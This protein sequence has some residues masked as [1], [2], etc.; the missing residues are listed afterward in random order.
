MFLTVS[1]N[2]VPIHLTGERWRHI[3]SRHPEISVLRKRIRETLAGPDMLADGG[4]GAVRAL[5]LYTTR[6]F[7]GQ[8]LV[9]VYAEVRPC[10]GF[11]LTAYI[12]SR[13][14]LNRAVLWRR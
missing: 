8:F 2:H 9:V 12:T 4:R 5:R 1:R 13:P 7:A 14:A 6:P 11:V 10:C 3:V